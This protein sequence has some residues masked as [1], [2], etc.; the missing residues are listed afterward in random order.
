MAALYRGH[1]EVARALIAL[2]A[3]L[4][5]FAAAAL[6]NVPALS[7]ALRQPGAANALAYD[8]LTPLHLAAFFGQL[9]AARAL[10][11]AGAELHAVSRSSMKNTP[12]HAAAAGKHEAIAL[13]LL[14]RGARPD[15]V[16][17][18]GYTAR[19]I[20]EENQLARVLEHRQIGLEQTHDERQLAGHDQQADDDEERA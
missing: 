17:G 8:G 18:G 14:D 4:D 16:D 7:E 15:I 20:A 11:D 12:L 10:V 5:V 13:L 9:D 2:G 6:G 1:V 19:R 3:E